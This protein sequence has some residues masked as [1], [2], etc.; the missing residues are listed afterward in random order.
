MLAGQA[1]A[2][3]TVIYS[4]ADSLQADKAHAMAL[5]F[6]PATIDRYMTP[7]VAWR[8]H[9]AASICGGKLVLLLW[10]ARAAASNEVRREIDTA[11]ICKVPV[12]PVLLDSTPLP[13]VLG[14]VNAV[15]W[16]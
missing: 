1:A 6:G 15:D 9:M 13:G 3:T 11:L 5:A 12:I 4:R 14:D 2:Q 8:A 10:S 7:G 16:R